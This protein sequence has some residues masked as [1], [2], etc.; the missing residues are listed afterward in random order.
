ME[1][2]RLHGGTIS[3]VSNTAGLA[4]SVGTGS[5]QIMATSGTIS[6]STTINVTAAVLQSIAVTPANPFIALG[7]TQQFI[8][9]GTFSDGSTQD[10]SSTVTWASDTISTVSVSKTGLATGIGTGTATVIATWATLT[11]S[12]VLTVAAATLASIIINPSNAVTPLNPPQQFTAT[13]TYTD[14]T[15]QDLTTLG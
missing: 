14:G 7:T 5:A 6:G 2:E 12:T 15:T 9:T 13:G 10:L 1:F 8:A 4:L 3:N 11:G